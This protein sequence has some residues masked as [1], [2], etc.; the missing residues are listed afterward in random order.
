M[1]RGTICSWKPPEICNINGMNRLVRFVVPGL[2]ILIG[3]GV[4]QPIAADK[5]FSVA[6][7]P[8]FSDYR[9]VTEVFARTHR[10]R[11]V[12]DFCIVGQ[13]AADDTKSAWVIWKQGQEILLWDGNGNDL[14]SSQRIIRLKKDV[15][16]TENDLHGST[17]LVTRAWVEALS[18]M[19]DK[20]GAKV[21]IPAQRKGKSD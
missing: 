9:H 18:S 19:C 7:D 21:Q 13:K 2:L 16:R 8:G 5:T 10:P 11:A 1:S 20:S 15:V 12:N 14:D 3:L 17:H 6:S 4:A